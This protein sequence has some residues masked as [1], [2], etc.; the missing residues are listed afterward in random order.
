MNK[1]IFIE[2][3]TDELIID[4]QHMYGV[5]N[6]IVTVGVEDIHVVISGADNVIILEGNASG[7]GRMACAI[8]D[9]VLKTCQVAK[10]YDLFSADSVLLDFTYP[11]GYPLMMVEMDAV[12]TF[13][14]MFL[15]DTHFI[16]G[17]SSEAREKN[18]VKVRIIARN[19][20]KKV[21]Y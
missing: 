11:E 3:P 4:A 5:R 8:E 16:W 2:N 20:K 15:K 19:I 6:G 7:K 18:D 21:N 12:T 9:A 17:I 14:E 1:P 13:A 10:G